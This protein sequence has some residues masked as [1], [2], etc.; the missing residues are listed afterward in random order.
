MNFNKINKN[1]I[2]FGT[3][4]TQ[5]NDEILPV[6]HSP[7][8]Y[9][10]TGTTLNNHLEGI[11]KSLN[12]SF[13]DIQ[14][15]LHSTELTSLELVGGVETK[16]SQD[17]GNVIYSYLNFVELYDNV[18]YRLKM[19]GLNERYLLSLSFF[20]K[21]ASTNTYIECFLRGVNATGGTLFDKIPIVKRLEKGTGVQNGINFK[22]EYY[23]G[24]Q[25]LI[26]GGFDVYLRPNNNIEIWQIDSTIFHL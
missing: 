10:V 22:L 17:G 1:Y 9:Y 8:S 15:S 18:N 20:A 24:S 21:T 19:N 5:V 11:D 3:G 26:E 2:D 7:S 13:I 16:L 23:S 14:S 6:K 12:G 25:D 4:N